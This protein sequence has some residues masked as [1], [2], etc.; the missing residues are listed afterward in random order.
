[1][2][3]WAAGAVAIPLLLH[4]IQRRRT[5]RIPF[6]TIRFLQLAR[7]RSSNRIRME[8]LLLWLLRTLIILLLVLAFAQPVLRT[9][10][11]GNLLS[12]GRRDVAIVLDVSSSMDYESGKEDVWSRAREAAKSV[13]RSLKEGDRACMFLAA[14]KPIPLIEKPSG[15]LQEMLQMLENQEV[16]PGTSN[17]RPALQA[18]TKALRQSGKRE[19]EIFVVTDGQAL[20]W[21]DFAEKDESPAEATDSPTNSP[22]AE[23]TPESGEWLDSEAVYFTA[24]TGAPNPRN[25]AP[26]GVEIA[27]EVIVAGQESR[28]TADILYSGDPAPTAMS[29]YI[30]DEEVVRR[31]VPAPGSGEALE[32][33][34]PPLQPG[35]H[36]AYVQT[37]ADSLQDDNRFYFLLHARDRLP[38]LC[39]GPEKDKFFLARA[40]NPSATLATIAVDD[41][42]SGTLAS[43]DLRDYSCI[44]LCNALPLS[45]ESVHRLEDFV[46]SG[47]L[48]TVFPG[49]RAG[50]AD[51]RNWRMLPAI[52]EAIKDYGDAPER[53][54]LHLMK[55]R[56][57]LFYSLEVP[58]GTAPAA[59]FK[60]ALQWD[61]LEE[62]GETIIQAGNSQPFLAGREYGRGRVLLFSVS[63]GRD[64]STFPLSPF[65]LP[66]MHQI[67]YYGADIGGMQLFVWCADNLRVSDYGFGIR[68]ESR[69]LTPEG[70]T[71]SVHVMKNKSGKSLFL[72]D[73]RSPGFYSLANN[74]GDK[75]VLAVNIDRRESNL[76]RIE[77]AELAQLTGI[78]NLR[79]AKNESGLMRLIEEHRQG[80]P[81]WELL[82]WLA[83]AL[84]LL[85]T[86][87]ANRLSRSSPALSTQMNLDRAGR[88]KGAKL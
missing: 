34:I 36:R 46:R 84:F 55:S 88:F 31:E 53:K 47:G 6:S 74:G 71:R 48:L 12:S 80:R 18:A 70:K 72:E 69:I 35:P 10:G 22:A 43:T 66:L 30:D 40:L 27:P 29:L 17:F 82:L 39:A 87:L 2:L 81:V 76:D 38:V 28:L 8:N 20:P 51:Y 86:F 3:L 37:P 85:E 25:I 16:L 23:S 15:K 83:L 7:K 19:K 1:M 52:P 13:I 41:I 62:E 14:E 75:P 63:A 9:T 64:W 77:S 57:N 54:I 11:F 78:G 32:F 67:V 33:R 79:I 21:S 45:G 68:E 65:F 56:D 26:S 60:R 5:T 59:T 50:I 44:F 42:A 24:L 61:E 4:L 58:P 73:I 49:G